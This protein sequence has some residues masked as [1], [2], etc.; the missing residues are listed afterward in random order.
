LLLKVDVA[1]MP[2]Y[3]EERFGPISFVVE[4]ATT[5]ESLS[6][7]ERVMREKGALTFMVHSTSQ[8]I[9]LLAEEISL[10]VGVALSINLTDGLSIN[11]SAGFSDYHATGANPAANAC[12]IDSAFVASRFFVVQSQRPV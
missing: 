3:A 11:Q 5:L 2:A 10:R 4:T 9:W 1:D 6:A 12:M 7:A 8:P